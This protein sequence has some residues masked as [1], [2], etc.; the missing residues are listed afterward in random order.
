[1]RLHS[2]Y[3]NPLMETI[4]IVEEV[5]KLCFVAQ[6]PYWVCDTDFVGIPGQ[7][8]PDPSLF[9]GATYV[10]ARAF[11]AIL[12]EERIVLNTSSHLTKSKGMKV[13]EWLVLC[14]RMRVRSNNGSQLVK[15]LHPIKIPLLRLH[16]MARL[17]FKRLS[18]IIFHRKALNFNFSLIKNGDLV[19]DVRAYMGDKTAMYVELGARIVSIEP[20]ET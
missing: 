9:L 7:P 2:I 15:Y 12:P 8:P 1:M 13:P 16:S 5:W 11:W 17:F 3:P 6:R 14:Q 20:Q 18:R 10:F 19:F 4:L